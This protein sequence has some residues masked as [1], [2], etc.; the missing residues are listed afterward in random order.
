RV[1]SKKRRLRPPF[2]RPPCRCPSRPERACRPV[3]SRSVA[4]K[5]RN[6]AIGLAAVALVVCLHFAI[7]WLAGHRSSLSPAPFEPTLERGEVLP[8]AEYRFSG[9]CTHGNLTVDRKS[10]RL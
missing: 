3:P 1:D 9:P 6:V 5:I 10:T 7:G 4:M 8:V 2:P